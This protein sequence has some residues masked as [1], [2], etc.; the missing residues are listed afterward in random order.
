LRKYLDEK[1]NIKKIENFDFDFDD[2]EDDW[3]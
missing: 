1:L 2:D 3:R